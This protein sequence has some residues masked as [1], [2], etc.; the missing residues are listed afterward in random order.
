MITSGHNW[1]HILVTPEVVRAAAQEVDPEG[2]LL[3][4]VHADVG[5]DVAL[6][7]VLDG[8]PVLQNVDVAHEN[9]PAKNRW[10][11]TDNIWSQ[12]VTTDNICDHNW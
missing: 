7:L 4:A 8:A 3:G 2:E 11:Q 9:S 5:A 10:S 6:A 12:L 1:S